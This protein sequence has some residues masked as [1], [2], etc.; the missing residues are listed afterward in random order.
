L[1]CKKSENAHANSYSTGWLADFSMYFGTNHSRN[2]NAQLSAI[3]RFLLPLV[4]HATT[5]HTNAVN[6]QNP[7]FRFSK[8]FFSGK[9]WWAPVQ[10]RQA[11]SG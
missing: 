8:T 6:M 5:S 3:A 9:Q 10:N 11:V 4:H 1:Q 2:L 7:N